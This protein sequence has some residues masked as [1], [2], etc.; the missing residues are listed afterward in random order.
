MNRHE[1]R[2]AASKSKDVANKSASNDG[3]ASSLATLHEAA[4]R[5]MQA[6][7]HLDAQLGCRRILELDAGH[8]DTLQLMGLLSL[9]AAQYD[10]AIEWVGRANLGDPEAGYLL[11][12]ATALEQ[13]GLHQEALKAFASAARQKPD[14]A[15]L[16]TRLANTL[17]VL[18][19]P[20]EAISSLEQ[21][22]V[23][24]PR[25]WSAVYSYVVLLFGQ[26]RFE[27]ALVSLNR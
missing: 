18:Q 11:S 16:W 3:G 23:L 19:R 27:D 24:N 12:L 21:A 1:R 10:A 14:D 13:Q 4:V 8:V 17:I 20:A 7:R 25:R 6:G 22:I 15:E 2:A 9:Q 5:H 26:Q